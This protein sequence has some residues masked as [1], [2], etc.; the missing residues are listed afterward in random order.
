MSRIYILTPTYHRFEKVKTSLLSLKKTIEECSQHDI[1]LLI[2]DN[3]SPKEMKAWLVEN[4]TGPKYKVFL[5]TKNIGKSNI[6]NYVWEHCDKDCEYVG[7]FD[8]DLVV[9]PEH[10]NWLNSCITVLKKDKS[11]GL[12]STDQLE[13][14]CH[15][16]RL[17]TKKK[18]VAGNDLLYGKF[19][20][21]AGGCVFLSKV[22]WMKIA[23]YKVRT[24]YGADDSYLLYAIGSLLKKETVVNLS[25]PLIH[26]HGD[27]AGYVDWKSKACQNLQGKK[28]IQ[29]PTKGYYDE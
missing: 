17:L 2:G 16:K 13:Q 5:S 19:H 7:S 12:V 8:S 18:N 23:G 20:A 10:P 22:D 4:F 1:T 15:L 26:P 14:C 29:R 3:N 9:S 27:E 25:G 6:L 24:L 28:G 21:I 11:I